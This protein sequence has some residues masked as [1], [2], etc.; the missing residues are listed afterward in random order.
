MT[1]GGAVVVVEQ[2]VYTYNCCTVDEAQRELTSRGNGS[3]RGRLHLPLL[4]VF[5]LFMPQY[6][7]V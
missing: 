2:I 4:S 7:T 6:S 1:V 3:K 5:T